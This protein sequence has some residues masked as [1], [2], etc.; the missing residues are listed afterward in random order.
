LV[1]ER[2]LLSVV[3]ETLEPLLVIVG[4]T[5][6]G[7]SALAV[8]VAEALDGEIVSADAFAVYRGLDI[9]TDKPPP[10][11]RRRVRHHLIDVADPRERFS[12]GAFAD[13]AIHAITDI[14]ARGRTPVVVG[15][16]LFYVR[17]LILGLFPSPPHD[18]EVRS[19]LE[20]SWARDAHS[21]FE[22]LRQV[23]PPS[24]EKIGPRDRQRSLRALEVHELT[25]V[26]LSEHWR[27]HR[28]SPRF[29]PLLAVPSHSR[30]VLYARIDARVDSM[31]S[32]G[33]EEE[34]NQLIASG[35]PRD[36][37]A[38]KAIG[39]RQIV[40]MFEGL[41]D[42]PIAIERT[43]SASRQLAKRQLTWLR[44]PREGAL[45]SVPVVEEG[46]TE[47]LIHIWNHHIGEGRER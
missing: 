43:K 13:A 44:S 45:H 2:V 38:L 12:A 35:I 22:R 16:T 30:E 31:F 32:S 34:V 11:M 4:P 39:Y 24:A 20:E 23:D 19:R 18:P 17:A 41:W 36:A 28:Q 21:V 9:G 6:S 42:R 7:K 1:A 15:G 40:Q 46:G 25:E 10:E 5:A 33:F 37:H 47:A 27:H 29:H 8:E 3:T 14:R 26:P